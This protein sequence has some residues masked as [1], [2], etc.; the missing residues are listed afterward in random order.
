MFCIGLVLLLIGLVLLTN[1][2]RI[3]QFESSFWTNLSNGVQADHVGK[4]FY[5]I[6]QIWMAGAIAALAGLLFTFASFIDKSVVSTW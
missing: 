4:K 1:G 6:N 5:L 3:Q 2:R